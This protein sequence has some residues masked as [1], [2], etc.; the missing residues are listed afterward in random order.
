MKDEDSQK[1]LNIL[2]G[3]A[4][5]YRTLF[6]NVAVGV[7]WLDLDGQILHSNPTMLRLSGY[8]DSEISRMK[9][10]ELFQ[11][12]G[13]LQQLLD[14][15]ALSALES[16][17][18]EKLVCKDGTSTPVH[19][20]GVRVALKGSEAI[21]LTADEIAPDNEVQ[22]RLQT[23]EHALEEKERTI[24]LKSIALGEVVDQI[25]AEKRILKET[26]AANIS[27]CILPIIAKLRLTDAPA[28]M[29]D[30]LDRTLEE[31]ADRFNIRVSRAAPNLSPRESEIIRMIHCG[32]TSKQIGQLLSISQETVEKHRRNI[33]RKVGISG[34]KV[35]LASFLSTGT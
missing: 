8:S 33:R 7:C 12:T 20:T 35:N 32:L 30:L 26:I 15:A 34:K 24:Q 31:I 10:K 19:L 16:H 29:L 27:D 9:A 13:E 3:L 4:G 28:E 17:T 1:T 14:G 23:A 22:T 11:D 18:E 21:L 25:E 5:I 6:Q 2:R